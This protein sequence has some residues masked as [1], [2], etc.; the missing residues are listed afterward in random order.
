VPAPGQI[1]VGVFVDLERRPDAGGHVKCWER[2]AE[3]ASSF[4]AELDLTVHYL[5]AASRIEPVSRNARYVLH[6][7]VISTGW[8]RFLDVGSGATDLG[9]L[10]PGLVRHLRGYDVLH[11]T[12]LFT[13]ARTALLWGRL[14]GKPVVSSLHTDLPRYTRTYGDEVLRRI[15]GE[16]A[17][18]RLLRERLRLPQRW[19]RFVRWRYDRF[20][21]RCDAVLVS[22]DEDA[23]RLRRVLP[24]HRIHRLRRGVDR[25]LFHPCKR[26]RPRLRRELGIPEDEPVLL[27]AG[28]VDETKRIDRLTEAVRELLAR[29]FRLHLV[30][31]GEGARSQRVS[32]ALGAAVHLPGNV[33]QQ[34][35]AWLYASAD[36]FV[37]PSESEIFPNVV[38]EARSSGLPVVLSARDFG[39]RLVR[40]PGIDGFLV[41][42]D[43]VADWCEA[44]D[45][46]LADPALRAASGAA[47]RKIVEESWPS[48]GE[49]LGADLLPVWK[50]AAQGRRGC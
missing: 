16:G 26:D 21:A 9:P 48:W 22:K 41:G 31:A 44:L 8:P 13:L 17:V 35:L 18:G 12:D 43:R 4:A 34:L 14:T 6:R 32:R 30:V 39:A 7:P 50:D 5:G 40:E 1:R 27:F 42:G 20:L 15:A 2:F 29:G 28:R 3:A 37:F 38:L 25:D 47:A 11:A 49:V 19:E 24:A 36:L 10:H 45:R 46:L 23:E 33:S